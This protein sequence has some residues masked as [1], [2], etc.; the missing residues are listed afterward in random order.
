MRYEGTVYR[1]P[2][3]ADDVLLQVTIGC[4]HNR[5]TFCNMFRDKRFRPVDERAIE[6]SL[7]EAR[8]EQPK[9][10]RVFLTDA[11]AFAL[12][13]ARL[14]RIAELVRAHLPHVTTITTYA[15]VRN[16]RAKTDV[17]LAAL[18]DAGYDDLYVGL[19]TG[20][21]DV[22]A[23]TRKGHT[24]RQAIEQMRRLNAAGIAHCDM[25]M[26][27]LAGT[28]RA[29]ESGEAAARLLNETRP[30]LVIPTTLGVFPGT[31][32]F[33][34]RRRGTFREASEHEVAREQIAFLENVRL[35]DAYYWA[36]HALNATP[37]AGDLGDASRQKMIARLE[38]SLA[39]PAARR[40]RRATL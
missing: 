10:E 9:A 27:G 39:R 6:A 8:W 14:L 5:C 13:A 26:L 24:T 19:E 23:S 28:G 25:L 17:E 29:R 4:T 36:A 7:M 22:L 20:L 38:R 2:V 31:E 1:P 21:D 30:F 18:R 12:P 33:E 3:E 15:S 35:P 37:L 32:L 11:D 34:A 40:A 16:V